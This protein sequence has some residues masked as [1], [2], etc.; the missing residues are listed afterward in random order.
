MGLYFPWACY[1]FCRVF[2]PENPCLLLYIYI[3]KG[4]IQVF[5]FLEGHKDDFAAQMRRTQTAF[6]CVLR[7][8]SFSLLAP[9]D[10]WQGEAACLSAE[11][12]RQVHAIKLNQN[13][14]LK[15]KKQIFEFVDSTRHATSPM[16]SLILFT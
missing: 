1:S 6:P 13:L 4:D 9:C 11:S 10:T 2:V 15:L 14:H 16:D 12:G 5:T 7:R 8:I 3:H